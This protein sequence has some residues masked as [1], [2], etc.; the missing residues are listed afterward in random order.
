MNNSNA[1]CSICLEEINQEN[2]CLLNCEHPFCKKCIDDYLERNNK[3]CPNCRANISSYSYNNTDYQLIFMNE[4]NNLQ[5]ITSMRN[6][7]HILL[8]A[9]RKLVKYGYFSIFSLFYLT[10]RY[11]ML[12]Y[13]YDSLQENEDNLKISLDTCHTNETELYNILV[14]QSYNVIV[15][16]P[17][18][19][20]A[21]KCSISEYSYE[22]CLEQNIYQ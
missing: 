18:Y 16:D 11:M 3:K 4:E 21:E 6:Q 19:N 8:N 15:Y 7:I 13:N 12:Q 20:Y 17:Y 14:D 5:Q 22:K 2:I 10:Y 9:N 1:T